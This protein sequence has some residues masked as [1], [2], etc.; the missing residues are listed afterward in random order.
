MNN[1]TYPMDSFL[2]PAHYFTTIKKTE[3]TNRMECLVNKQPEPCMYYCQQMTAVEFKGL[4][5]ADVLREEVNCYEKMGIPVEYY[6]TAMCNA[7]E[8][9]F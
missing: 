8:D 2:L 3:V 1:L 5:F 4:D 7:H 6:G 9:R